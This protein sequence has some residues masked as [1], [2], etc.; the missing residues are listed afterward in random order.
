MQT[1]SP[2]SHHHQEL[3]QTLPSQLYI[4]SL[5]VHSWPMAS[6]ST[7][8]AVGRI[9]LQPTHPLSSFLL[10]IHPS[11]LA[12]LWLI[13]PLPSLTF[14]PTASLFPGTPCCPMFL[15]FNFFLSTVISVVHNGVQVSRTWKQIIRKLQSPPD[16]LGSST[17]AH[18]VVLHKLYLL[19]SV[20]PC[21]CLHFFISKHPSNF[22]VHLNASSA[23]TI[24]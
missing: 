16:D 7:W 3:P 4:S 14:I 12:L 13:F 1:W 11:F 2:C 23:P 22:W 6:S 19:Q 20:N 8:E 5:C 9:P 24:G 21:P 18:R 15:T 17:P 10:Y